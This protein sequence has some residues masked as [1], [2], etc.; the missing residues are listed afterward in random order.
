MEST[1][2]F[3]D[4]AVGDSLTFGYA[5]ATIPYPV[6]L[7]GL[8][9][10]PV[11]NLGV[12]GCRASAGYDRWQRYAKNFPYRFCIIFIGTNDLDFDS[13]TGASVFATVQTWIEEAVAA[14]QQVIGCTITPRDGSS[15]WTEA[16][17][18]ERQAYNTLLRAYGAAHPEAQIVDLDF[19]VSDDGLTVK[20]AHNYGDN[21]HFNNAG[22]A[23]VAAAVY[24]KI[25][26]ALAAS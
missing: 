4:V 20:A 11:T 26:A 10:S 12:G 6:A 17:E 9:G 2:E 15:G 3:A 5:V 25:V 23:A 22:F 7:S 21:L 24:A 1:R 8:T 14:G 18:E 16:K 19:V 13:A